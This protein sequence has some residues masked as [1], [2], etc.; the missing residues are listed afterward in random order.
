[1]GAGIARIDFRRFIGYQFAYAAIWFALGVLIVLARLGQFE[2][3]VERV[4]Q[5]R[6]R[7]R[8]EHVAA[9]FLRALF[10]R[11]RRAG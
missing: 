1:M 5:G 6:G 2:R 7:G 9:L 8:F 4:R 3:Y 11:T 10:N